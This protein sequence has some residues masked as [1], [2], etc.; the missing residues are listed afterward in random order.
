[1]LGSALH[2][3]GALPLDP[4]TFEKV[5][6]TFILRF[7]PYPEMPAL[8][9]RLSVY[10]D[11]LPGD[12]GRGGARQVQERVGDILRLADAAEGDLADQGLDDLLGHGL[13]RGPPR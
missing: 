4:T 8:C 2:P 12:I 9:P 10:M 5:D 1:M 13:H 3:P 11:H 7:A 6:E